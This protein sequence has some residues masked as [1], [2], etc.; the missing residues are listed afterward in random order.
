MGRKGKSKGYM[1]RTALRFT[2]STRPFQTQ[3]RKR[4][5]AA[6]RKRGRRQAHLANRRGVKRHRFDD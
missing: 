5:Q 1:H 2:G 3:P 4:S 6:R